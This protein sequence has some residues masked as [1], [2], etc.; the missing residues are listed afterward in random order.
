MEEKESMILGPAGLYKLVAERLRSWRT[1]NGDVFVDVWMEDIRHTVPVKSEAFTGILYMIAAKGAPG[2]LPSAKALEEIKAYCIGTA[3]ASQRI[4]PAYVRV[5]G[6]SRVLYYDF[7]D[8]SREMV[9]WKEG[10]W[11]II[12]ITGECPRFYRP[13]GMLPQVR[14]QGGGDLM[15][16]LGKHIRCRDEDLYLLAAWL[17]GAF[18]VGGPFPVLIINGEQGSSKSTT[19]RLLRRLVDPHARDMREPPTNSRDLVAAV[20]NA[21]VVAVD[22]VSTLQHNLSDSLCRIS[23]G[24]GALGGRALY[25]DSDEAAFTACRP[26]V[27]NGIPAFAEREDLVSRSI[28]VELPAIPATQRMDDDTFWH[29]FEA[30]M[31]RILGAIFDCVARAQ[32]GFAAVRLSEAPRMANFARW[33]FAGLGEEAGSRFLSAYSNNKMEASAHFVEHNDVAQAL[34]SL[35]KEKEVW[36]GSWAQ[37]LC[38]LTLHGAPSKFWPE[39]SLQLRNRMIRIS[40]DLR[41]CGIEWRK[42]G[43]ESRSG[44][45]CVEVR[46]LKSFIANHVLTSVT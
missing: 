29:N 9:R 17:V 19:T 46:R 38:D 24:T 21:Y 4:L 18:K 39:N 32:T 26:I 2:K 44:R 35:M 42:N 22:N 40:E 15:E 30:D 36:Y 10:I 23:T 3:L 6:D 25:T 14:P 43:R 1:P 13:N 31:P 27:L 34:I 12:R 8:D 33:A 5:G 41:K 37:L 11:E 16:L 20:K 28:N 7:G 45:S